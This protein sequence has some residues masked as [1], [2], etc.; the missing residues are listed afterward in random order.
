[1]RRGKETGIFIGIAVAFAVL[2]FAALLLLGSVDQQKQAIAWVNHTRDVLDKIT[3]VVNLLSDAENGRRGYVLTARENYLGHFTNRVA[4][5]EQSLA[6]L[7]ALTLDNPSQTAACDQMQILIRQRLAISTNSIQA[8]QGKGLNVPEQISF[9]QQGQQ[10]MDLIR[11]LANQMSKEESD[12]LTERHAAQQKSIDGTK[13]FAVLVALLALIVFTFL[14]ILFIRAN[15]RRNAAE[16]ALH[17]SHQQLEQRVEERTLELKKTQADFDRQRSELQLILDT[18]PAVIFFKDRE[19]R[20]VRVNQ[21]LC[22]L[23]GLPKDALEG[24]TDRD[25]GTPHAQRYID[26]EEE[27]IRTGQPKRGIIEPLA[28]ATG[29]HW[30]QTDKLPIRDA[31]GQIVGIIGLAVDIT[32]RKRAEEALTQERNLLRILIDHL[33]AC[34]YLKDHEGRFL[35]FNAASV[36]IV[37]LK[38]EADAIGKTVRDFFPPEIAEHYIADDLRVIESGQPILDREEPTQDAEGRRGWFLTTKIPFTDPSGQAGLLGISQDITERKQAEVLL[39]EAMTREQELRLKAQA[40]EDRFRTLVEQSLVG[41]Y[42]I[43]DGHFVY[44]NPAIAAVNG[45]SVA[46]LLSL[47]VLE[48]VVPEDRDLVRE[49]IRKRMDGIETAIQ[50]SLRM[51]RRDQ[52]IATVEVRGGVTEFNGKPA[53][54]GTMLDISERK[55]AEEKILRLNLELE[56]RVLQR[57]AELQSANRELE[58]FSYSVSHDL[59]APL[60]HIH[61]YV[62]MLKHDTAGQ[63]APGAR[64]YLDT[65]ERSSL[66]MGR[67]IDALLSFSRLGRAEIAHQRVDP[68]HLIDETI[69]GL[70]L[71]IQGRNIH[72]KIGHLPNVLGDPGTLKQV[73][74]NLIDNALK[75]SRERNPAVIEISAHGERDGRVIFCVRDNGAGFEMKYANKLFGVFHR[76]HRADEFEGTGIG[77]ATVRRIIQRHGGEVWAEAEVDKGAQFYFTLKCA[78]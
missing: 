61:G 77:L 62:Q 30:L 37:G 57:T 1:M 17:R 47:P 52:T 9:M 68:R 4:A 43:Q 20:L 23:L 25:L 38:S 78:S 18:V 63:L 7:R 31:A 48:F 34:I 8:V 46:E 56:E 32:E 50:Y 2:I 67:L 73:F 27:I 15:R 22:R 58:S 44:V 42:V 12:R 35:I 60:R 29:V 72:W 53:I 65:I 40:S 24:R 5:A 39:R 76:L 74:V 33:P 45:Y 36:R 41:I 3:E 64:R 66:E 54:L 59:R 69:R 11:Q 70:E 51:L 49:N 26:D 71:I 21:E 19:H 6:E 10:S 55:A 75:Y 13:G 16:E 14:L 28:T